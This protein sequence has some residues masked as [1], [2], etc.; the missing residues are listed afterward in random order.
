[1]QL[2]QLPIRDSAYEVIAVFTYSNINS[3]YLIPTNITIPAGTQN[4][5]C[6]VAWDTNANALKTSGTVD[7]QILYI[8]E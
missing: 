4:F 3:M 6:A 8:S 5:K 7:I 1:M 2:S